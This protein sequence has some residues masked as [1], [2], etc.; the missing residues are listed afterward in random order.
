MICP[1][2][3]V[4]CEHCSDEIERI[5]TRTGDIVTGIKRKVTIVPKGAF[6]NNDGKHYVKDL[7]ECPVPG[8]LS[9]PLVVPDMDPVLWMKIKGGL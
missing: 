9:V 8:A 6:C 2:T 3:G 1:K 7:I 5:V 4:T